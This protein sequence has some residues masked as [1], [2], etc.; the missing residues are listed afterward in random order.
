MIDDTVVKGDKGW[1]R[2]TSI[3]NKIFNEK[4]YEIRSSF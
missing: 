3:G 4:Y 1:V 2:R